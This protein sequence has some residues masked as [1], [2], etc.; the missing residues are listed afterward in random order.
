MCYLVWNNNDW[1]GHHTQTHKLGPS[2]IRQA[3][4]NNTR[5]ETAATQ[6]ISSPLT[7]WVCL[8]TGIFANLYHPQQHQTSDL[9]LVQASLHAFS[10]HSIRRARFR[11]SASVI[12]LLN[13]RARGTQ[14]THSRLLCKASRAANLIKISSPRSAQTFFSPSWCS[15]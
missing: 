7:T 14:F 12:L 4:W 10:R 3:G 2:L 13:L 8:S 11:F 15:V 5:A 6:V 9:R 1:A